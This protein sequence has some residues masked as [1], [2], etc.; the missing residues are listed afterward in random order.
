MAISRTSSDESEFIS[1]FQIVSY[2]FPH[3]Q[4]AVA[5]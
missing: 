5:W 1:S 4:R 2:S 3:T